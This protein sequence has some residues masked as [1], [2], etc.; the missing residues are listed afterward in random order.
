MCKLRNLFLYIVLIACITSSM[1]ASGNTEKSSIPKTTNEVI[2]IYSSRHYDVDQ[3]IYN[4][5][6]QATGIAINVVTGKSNEILAKAMLEGERTQAD[7]FFVVGAEI[8]AELKRSDVLQSIPSD[9]T[10]AVPQGFR[11]IDNQWVAISKRARVI[12]YD[13]TKTNPTVNSY[14]DLVQG[15]HSVLIRSS[16]NSYNRMLVASILYANG[17]QAT[18]QWVRDLVANLAR[19]PQGN[20]RAQA[21]ALVSGIG[22][23]AVM[24]SYYIGLMLRS[25]DSN[26]KEVG[27]KLGI[28]FPNQDTRGTHVNVTGIGLSKYAQNKDNAIKLIQFFLS[29]AVQEKIVQENFEYPILPS[30]SLPAIMESW[31]TFKEDVPKNFND[32]GVLVPLVAQ[33]SDEEGWQ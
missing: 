5:F 29:K 31:G 19:P 20:D 8:L 14:E 4:N 1:Y 32:I 16:S 12:V 22:D 25:D 18:R 33:I 21:K 17:E 6:T 2:N 27:E 9:V 15:P 7:L 28:I 26:E 10:S 23:Y 24:N 13:K 11:D 3:E 30:I